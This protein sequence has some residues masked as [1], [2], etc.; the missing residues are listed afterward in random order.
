MLELKLIRT[1]INTLGSE[2]YLQDA[3][4]IYDSPDNEGGWG[5]PNPE[6][7]SKALLVSAFNNTSDGPKEATVQEYDPETVTDFVMESLVD[8]YYEV[9][10]VAVDK[11]IPTVE[12][13]YGWT[14][15]SGL[16]RLE[17]GVNVSVKPEDL[18][19]DPTFDDSVSYKTVIIARSAIYRNTKNLELVN[20]RMAHFED[21]GHNREIEDLQ[22]HYNTVKA[23]IDGSLYAWCSDNYTEAQRILESFNTITNE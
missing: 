1:G 10:A 5:I 15:D 16:V 9:F 18:Y 7:N 2:M 8:G 4:G 23:L 11:S 17:D 22:E 13:D 14:I 21:R 12:G 6:R 20:L 3:T 19:N